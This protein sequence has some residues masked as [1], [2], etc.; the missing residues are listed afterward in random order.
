MKTSLASGAGAT[1]RR[2]VPLLVAAMTFAASSDAVPLLGG[3]GGPAGYGAG[4]LGSNDDG[5]TGTID[6]SSAFSTGANFY[7]ARFSP[8]RAF[9][10]AVWVNNNGNV[11]FHAGV[12]TYTPLPF[13]VADQPM[14]AP[15][16]G[17]V[18]TRA[19][20]VADGTWNRV[21]Y[22]V[23]P[24]GAGMPTGGASPGRFIATWHYVGFYNANNSRLDDFQVVLTNRGDIV[25]GDFDVELRYNQCSW[26]TGDASGGSGG[27]GGTPAQAG[28][29]AGNSTDFFALPGSRT[30]AVL[31]LCATSNVVPAVPGLWRF[32]VR[33]GGVAVC[34]N[35]VREAGEECDD[36]NTRPGD[37]CS[38]NCT[39]EAPNGTPCGTASRC[40][41]G[42][43]VDG[44]CCDSACGGQCQACNAAGSCTPVTGAPHGA[45]PA[46][47]GSGACAGSCNGVTSNAC[48]FP[49]TATTCAAPHCDGSLFTPAAGCNGM[50]ACGTPGATMC[51]PYRCAGA[52][53]GTTCTSD[54]DCTAGN[55]CDPTGHCVPTT[56]P[57]SGCTAN[58]QCASGF[59]VDGFCCGSACAGSCEACDVP[60]MQGT[61]VPVTGAPHGART[62][63]VGGTGPCAGTCGGTLRASCVYP[64]NTTACRAASCSMGVATEAATCN[65]A[66]LCPDPVTHMCMPFL[67]ASAAC[68]T[69]CTTSADCAE[70]S[71]CDGTS[72]MPRRPPGAGCGINDECAT[73]F[74]ADGVCCNQACNGQCEACN[75]PTSPGTCAAVTGAPQ[76]MR[77]ACGGTG[78]C[79]GTCDGVTRVS[80][81]YPDT[82]T[83]CREATCTD[84]VA[85]AGANCDGLGNCPATVTSQ[86]APYHCM[87]A[88][89]A[90]RCIDN[91]DCAGGTSCVMGVCE[92]P[93]SNGTGC[94]MNGQC[95]SGTCS[96]GV[97]CNRSCD[98]F[99]E[100]CNAELTGGNCIARAAGDRPIV[101]GTSTS[102]PP[103]GC[104]CDGNGMCI[105]GFD[106]GVTRDASVADV[107]RPTDRP[108]A[109]V[110]VG[111]DVAPVEYALEGSGCGCRTAGSS[112]SRAN[113]AWLAGLAL[114]AVGA[115]RR[116]RSAGGA[117]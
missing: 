97:C 61:C 64:D 110:P 108:R 34:G 99:C 59:C 53:C 44:V 20:P 113:G 84:D 43:C 15:W 29:D 85:T 42:F 100:T 16:W 112:G 115:R 105:V 93:R 76:G 72:C 22:Y 41:S 83:R 89:C 117:R 106:A 98:G 6:I 26:T 75:L 116:R 12:S 38:A 45:R 66:G 62:A 70:G 2:V 47:G 77:S 96:Q 55:F 49:G 48:T 10:R 18:D 68:A 80:C 25:A 92:G 87:G 104:L 21:F 14:I 27:L 36:G 23:E 114:A 17:D 94:T 33:S 88:V 90:T 86:C 1:F 24:T 19:Q 3:F 69:G 101:T 40:R 58:N 73:G 60:G 79:A 111:F 52:A 7:C 102:R 71:Y 78:T 103:D 4:E 107:A 37:G 11:T 35:G 28:F 91:S 50:G 32:N 57:G 8:A 31:N 56:P 54:A 63:C 13:P 30:G 39:L 95:R 9:Y 46:C 5:S 109:D 74:C 65:G 82:M 67:C 81:V 51:A